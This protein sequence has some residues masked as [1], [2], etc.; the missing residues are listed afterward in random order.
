MSWLREKQFKEQ[1]QVFS[2]RLVPKLKE[3]VKDLSNQKAIIRQE[4]E[5]W[6]MRNEELETRLITEGQ[7]MWSMKQICLE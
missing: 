6:Q 3:R 1:V 2:D 5:M 7:K 4:V